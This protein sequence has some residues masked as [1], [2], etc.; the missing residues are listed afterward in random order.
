[1]GYAAPVRGCALVHRCTLAVVEVRSVRNVLIVRHG[2]ISGRRG[3]ILTVIPTVVVRR[4]IVILTVLKAVIRRWIICRWIVI[5]AVVPAVDIRR[6][7]IAGGRI[8]SIAGAVDRPGVVE[9][10]ETGRGEGREQGVRGGN[11][12]RRDG[13]PD[14]QAAEVKS[15]RAAPTRTPAP[16]PGFSRFPAGCNSSSEILIFACRRIG[17]VV[18]CGRSIHRASERH[19]VGHPLGV[20]RS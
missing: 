17:R 7:V 5:G 2:L 8:R 1:M 12:R 10:L 4:W 18:K 16:R 19:G 11:D 3:I 9:G 6:R 13:E 20:V 14:G 15:G